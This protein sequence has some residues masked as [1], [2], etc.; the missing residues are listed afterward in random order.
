MRPLLHL[1]VFLAVALA[2][3]A[4][5]R[6]PENQ[7]FQWAHTGTSAPWPD[8]STRTATLYLWVPE[9]CA[10]VR[11]LVILAT[12]VPEH[13]LVGH[14]AIRRA[15]RE[16]DLALVWG[17]P[18]FWRFGKVAPA[19]GEAPIEV[20]NLPG[21]DVRQVE[22][23]EQLL[24][25]LA[26]KSG[27]AEI[28]RAPWLP[29]GESGHLLM[30]VGL[31]N[32]RPSRCIAAICVKNPQ[33][34]KDPTVPMLWTLGT[35][36]EWGQS[37]VDIR[38]HWKNTGNYP[39]WV[40]DRAK[41]NAPLSVI[42]EPG[43]GHFYCSDAMAEH[44]GRYIAAAA[45]A[46]LPE[47]DGEPLKPV[48]LAAGVLA[49]LPIP[50]IADNELDVLPAATAPADAR[51]R[52]WFF[53]EKLARDAQRLSRTKWDAAP[54]FVG[55]TAGQGAK[56]ELFALNS[57]TKATITTDGEFEI[58]AE[59]LERIPAGFIGAGELLARGPGEAIVEWICGPVAPVAPGKFRIAL[60]RTWKTGGACY[61]IARHEGDDTV[62]RTVQP[63]HVTLVE[64]KEGAANK[65]TFDRITDQTNGATGVALR[66]Q[67]SS[68]LPVQFFV[69]SGPAVV[70]NDR[71]E[72]TAVPP[73]AKWPVEIVVAA[74]QWGR[75][76][77]PKVRTA[78]IVRQ[79]FF[80][81]PSS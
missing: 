28:A 17:V 46:R 35:G 8:G 49:N 38:D 48:P 42:I 81:R 30:V 65:I 72:F 37:K 36:Q 13:M 26:A 73:G 61:L 34:P 32:E 51:D 15:C 1:F 76:T 6:S 41:A 10:R 16:N 33:T 71:L 21:S 19:P 3:V 80:L 58:G 2:A 47:K 66:A 24:S 69:V 43:T 7:V 40:A 79:S 53:N 14:E 20:K 78:E 75:P 50:G 44:F 4:A 22:F 27:Y 31:V 77:D 9:N 54:Q 23:L 60:D 67:A 62:R 63:L 45:R 11:G 57:V 64:N 59:L 70:R 74:W 68:G 18:T 56:L 29:I 5:P 25:G 12:N 52:A 55:F 39:K